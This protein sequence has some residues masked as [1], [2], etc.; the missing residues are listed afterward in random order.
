M[1][2]SRKPT[3]FHLERDTLM[4][5]INREYSLLSSGSLHI[6]QRNKETLLIVIIKEKILQHFPRLKLNILFWSC[7]LMKVS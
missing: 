6:D 1:N 7:I 4:L 2:I 5:K 3:S